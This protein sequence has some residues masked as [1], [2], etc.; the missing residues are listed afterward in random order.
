MKLFSTLLLSSE[1]SKNA[2][3]QRNRLV[4]HIDNDIWG[5]SEIDAMISEMELEQ[6]SDTSIHIIMEYARQKSCPR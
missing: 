4:N 1:T 5:S 6:P 2:S 3:I